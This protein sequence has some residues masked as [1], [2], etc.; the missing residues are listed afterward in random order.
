MRSA[1]GVRV[2]LVVPMAASS[3]GT[4]EAR[5]AEFIAREKLS[6]SVPEEPELEE[7]NPHRETCPATCQ[8]PFGSSGCTDE[9]QRGSSAGFLKTQGS[10][11]RVSLTAVLSG[12][13]QLASDFVEYFAKK[14]HPLRM[15]N[16]DS[17]VLIYQ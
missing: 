3:S 2:V 10:R 12:A 1:F 16:I 13:V 8:L 14:F 11:M 15:G 9:S 4:A 6:C 5:L 7:S 17:Y